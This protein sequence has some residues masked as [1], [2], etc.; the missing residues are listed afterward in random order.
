MKKGID[1][2][3]AH[4]TVTTIK[5]QSQSHALVLNYYNTRYLLYVVELGEVGSNK[6]SNLHDKDS[7]LR[8]LY[9]VH[10]YL[11]SAPVVRIPVAQRIVSIGDIFV[12]AHKTD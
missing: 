1:D 8:I 7:F 12:A 4:R 5:A 11:F 6:A 3:N 10:K 2:R 9:L